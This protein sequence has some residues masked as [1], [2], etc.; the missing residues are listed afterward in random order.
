MWP[1]KRTMPLDIVV[2][3][4][5]ALSIRPNDV[6]VVEVP[7]G[8]PQTQMEA[9]RDIFQRAFGSTPAVVLVVHAGTDIKLYRGLLSSDE[10]ESAEPPLAVGEPL[11]KGL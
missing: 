6:L 4:V 2:T 11:H 3:Q 5:K 7:R 9:A 10:D 1:F 8:T